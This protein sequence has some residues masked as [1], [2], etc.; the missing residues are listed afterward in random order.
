MMEQ[1]ALFIIEYLQPEIYTES[2][3]YE[4]QEYIL[5]LKFNVKIEALFIPATFV[6]QPN[7]FIKLVIID[8]GIDRS[9][10]PDPG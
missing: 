5:I 1:E 3:I 10:L 4:W 2:C 6:E 7:H 9:D 8:N